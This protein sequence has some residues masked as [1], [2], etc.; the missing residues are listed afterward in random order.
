[1][2][3][4]VLM[5]I[6]CCSTFQEA[7]SQVKFGN[8]TQDG[9]LGIVSLIGLINGHKKEI[10][11]TSEIEEYSVVLKD[12]TQMQLLSKIYLDSTGRTYLK[13]EAK[14][15]ENS[16]LLIDKKLYCNNT[17]NILRLETK[18]KASV[19][20]IVT[21][22]CW[23][24]KVLKGKINIYSFIPDLNVNS[25]YIKAIQIG[26]GNIESLNEQRLRILMEGNLRA[27]NALDKKDYYKAI[28]RYNRS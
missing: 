11:F 14:T 24:F 26:D 27:L 6:V 19:E 16:N 23:L 21:D 4:F 1:M 20:G 8:P 7:N 25:S 9:V 2:R 3:I 13:Y 5:M 18:R 12:S 22:S 10:S 28:Y 15:S 17:L